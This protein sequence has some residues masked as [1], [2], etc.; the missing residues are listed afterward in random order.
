VLRSLLASLQT[1]TVWTK[2]SLHDALQAQSAASGLALGK[3]AQPLRVAVT[4]GSVSP[5][6]DITL[7][8]LG[9]SETFQRLTRAIDWIEQRDAQR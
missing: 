5:P 2:E 3:I 4:G 9:R 1:L 8:V 6:I 7:E